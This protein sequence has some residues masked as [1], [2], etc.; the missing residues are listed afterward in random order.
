MTDSASKTIVLYTKGAKIGNET[1]K[2]L[3]AAGYIPILVESPDDLRVLGLAI[4]QARLDMVTQAAFASI[5]AFSEGPP[6]EFGSRLAKL[7]AAK[8]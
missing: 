3:M 4:P 6:K 2:Q 8:S 5:A 7:L 1:R